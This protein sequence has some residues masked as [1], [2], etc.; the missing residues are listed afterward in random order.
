MELDSLLPLSSEELEGVGAGGSEEEEVGVSEEE[1]AG[2]SEEEA[3][4]SEDEALGELSL[5]VPLEVPCEEL[6]EEGVAE[7]EAGAPP[8]EVRNK[9]VSTSNVGI[10]FF[11]F[12][13]LNGWFIRVY[14]KNAYQR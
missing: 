6:S 7:V 2:V 3:G 14:T 5:E 1:E 12:S 10:G 13:L 11:M 8:Q 4:V 9:A